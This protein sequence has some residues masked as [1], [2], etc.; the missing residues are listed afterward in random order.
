MTEGFLHALSGDERAALDAGLPQPSEI[1][2]LVGFLLS[3]SA[4]ST[5]GQRLVVCAGVSL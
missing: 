4:R 3:P 1:A 5:T 2:D